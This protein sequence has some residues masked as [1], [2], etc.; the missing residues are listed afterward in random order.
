MILDFRQPPIDPRLTWLNPPRRWR[1]DPTAGLVLEPDATT[2]FWQH[3]HYGFRV[4]SGHFLGMPVKGDFVLSTTVAFHPVH[5][6][7]QA[8]LMLRADASYW[9]KASVEHEQ[10]GPAQLGAVLTT[11]GFSDWSLQDCPSIGKEIEWR[12]SKRGLNLTVEYKPVDQAEWKL[13]RVAHWHAPE[14]AGLHTGLYACSPKGEGFRAEF[15]YLR[16][17]ES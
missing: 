17:I 4:D 13:V 14:Q 8:G 3:T 7:D 12:L 16:L 10:H 1:L 15:K 9:L 11:H 2:D 6:Y 5:Q